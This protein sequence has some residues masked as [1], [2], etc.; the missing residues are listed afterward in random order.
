MAAAKPPEF[1]D[2]DVLALTAGGRAELHG[3]ETGLAREALKVLVLVDGK[4][5][6]SQVIRSMPGM[7]AEA[8]RGTLTEMLDGG[9]IAKGG[10]QPAYGGIDPGD[11]FTVTSADAKFAA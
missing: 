6:V 4:A 5:S 3:S 10:G 11:F 2:G 8:V 1:D 7:S 9:Y